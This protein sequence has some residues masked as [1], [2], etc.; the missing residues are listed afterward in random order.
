MAE[1]K[2]SA[3]SPRYHRERRYPLEPLLTAMGCTLSA[4]QP[5]LGIGGPEYRKYS[6]EGMSREV[7]E[8]KANRAG[9]P[10]YF[11]WPEMVEHDLAHADAVRRARLNEIASRYR[12]NHPERRESE[13][14]RSR[15]Y[16]AECADYVRA[17]ERRRYREN[18][19][20]I[21]AQKKAYREANAERISAQKKAYYLANAERIKAAERERKAKRRAE[22]ANQEEQKA[23]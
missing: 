6:E 8:R 17:R 22:Q 19:E 13:R 9:L 3:P 2:E 21:K 11:V 1:P 10:V 5:K 15:A 16:Y 4:A 23:A 20:R 7:A 14:E 18:A 12:D